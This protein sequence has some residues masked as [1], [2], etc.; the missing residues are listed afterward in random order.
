MHRR[1]LAPVEHPALEEG[2]VGGNAHKPAQ[3]VDLPHQMALCG[4]AD[5]GIAG[6]VADEVQ[7]QGKDGGAGAQSGCRVGGFDARMARA[8]D[9]DVVAA[10]MIDQDGSVLSEFYMV[11]VDIV[12]FGKTGGWLQARFIINFIW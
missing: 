12:A 3:G 8:N 6:H 1:S 7:C 11:I 4:A 9:D 2:G 10:K 5:G